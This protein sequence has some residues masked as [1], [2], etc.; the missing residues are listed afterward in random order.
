MQIP[1]GF[2]PGSHYLN[3]FPDDKPLF[4]ITAKNVDQ[5]RKKLTAG[6]LALMEAY[7]ETFKIPVYKTRRTA[8][9]PDRIYNNTRKAATKAQL[10]PG[11]NGF[12]G[13]YDAYP[14]PVP[15]NGLEVLWNHIVRYRGE[16]VVRRSSE[17]PVQR[18]GTYSLST[19][20][21]E[22][23]VNYNLPGGS[24]ESLDNVIFYY[25]SFARSPA[26]LAGGAVLV[27]ETLDQVKQ[28]RQAWSYNAGQRRVRRGT[29]PL[30]RYPYCGFRGFAHSRRHR[31][32]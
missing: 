26:R 20:Q 2:K 8:R 28:P 1:K 13:A 6:Q 17:A 4:T 16:Y 7:P 12:T 22:A 24:E 11:G 25:L 21:Q 19:S 32:V 5:Y 14:F 31:H 10:L 30:L 3:P 29:Q 15:Q 23:L 27:H 18:N 9:Q